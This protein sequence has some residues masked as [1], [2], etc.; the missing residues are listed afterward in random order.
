MCENLRVSRMSRQESSIKEAYACT[1]SPPGASVP[2]TDRVPVCLQAAPNP[3]TTARQVADD[4]QRLALDQEHL[5]S[6]VS[7]G[8]F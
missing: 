7:R 6:Q 1:Y 5:A 2:L 8:A 4:I 3:A